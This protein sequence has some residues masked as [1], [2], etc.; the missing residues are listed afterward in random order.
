M[1]DFSPGQL[2][3]GQLTLSLVALWVRK[4]QHVFLAALS[5][6]VSL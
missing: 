3:I 1:A 6:F 4:T 2:L 5:I